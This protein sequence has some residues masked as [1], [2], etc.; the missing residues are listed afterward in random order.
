MQQRRQKLRYVRW[1]RGLLLNWI[2]KWLSTWQITCW[3]SLP[4]AVAVA[5]LRVRLCACST[6][7]AG[8]TARWAWDSASNIAVHR[9]RTHPKRKYFPS[10][11]HT[12]THESSK[13]T[14]HLTN[15]VC[16]LAFVLSHQESKS[17][18][19]P[20]SPLAYYPRAFPVP[21]AKWFGELKPALCT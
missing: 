20:R 17:S 16:R 15:D 2:E 10:P 7:R 12:H 18:W 21:M 11:T 5:K 13:W 4:A 19:W 1:P 3:V 9:P 8:V 6:L 14:K